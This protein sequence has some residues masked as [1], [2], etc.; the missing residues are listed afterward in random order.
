MSG[1]VTCAAC[2]GFVVHPCR[3]CLHCG[4][5]PPSRRGFARILASRLVGV[6]ATIT[7]MACY[8]AMPDPSDDD[9]YGGGSC[10]E[11][12]DAAVPD[13]RVVPD[14]EVPDAEVSDTGI[15]DPADGCAALD[16]PACMITEGCSASYTGVDCTHPDGGPCTP[17]APCTCDSFVFARCLVD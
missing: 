16:E 12:P 6:G 3:A 8:G 5:A 13:A 14:A 17:G 15:A 10:W 2:H 4:V 7:L 9:C 11:A 1:L